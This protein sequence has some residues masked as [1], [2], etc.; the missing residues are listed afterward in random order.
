MYN[1]FIQ[2]YSCFTSSLLW[3]SVRHKR[4][5]RNCTLQVS[6]FMLKARQRGITRGQDDDV[7]APWLLSLFE[8]AAYSECDRKCAHRRVAAFHST[9]GH[10]AGIR[11]WLRTRVY[12]IVIWASSVDR[13]GCDLWPTS[14]IVNSKLFAWNYWVKP[15]LAIGS[16][17]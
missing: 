3:K 2:K 13:K 15:W 9:H 16:V 5:D 12:G 7:S 17:F 10:N 1:S 14:I 6:P 4:S 11:Q 8:R